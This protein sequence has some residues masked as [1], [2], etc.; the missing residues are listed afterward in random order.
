MG[1]KLKQ[2]KGSCLPTQSSPKSNRK[3][4]SGKYP[5]PA[6]EESMKLKKC[7]EALQKYVH[8]DTPEERLEVLGI[9]ADIPEILA[10]IAVKDEHEL[11][12]RRA[13]EML[14]ERLGFFGMG[15]SSEAFE[16]LGNMGEVGELVYIILNSENFETRVNA[17]SALPSDMGIYSYLIHRLN[18]SG[19][20][21]DSSLLRIMWDLLRT[22]SMVC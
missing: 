13:R 1:K 11:V 5:V 8:A 17:L 16:G 2:K 9:V 22:E 3:K 15:G 6:L 12:R 20:P 4:T 19:S 7:K 18:K 14:R 10:D 21:D